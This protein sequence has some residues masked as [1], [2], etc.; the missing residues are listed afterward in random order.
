MNHKY[1]PTKKELL[2]HVIKQGLNIVL[3]W[4]LE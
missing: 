3:M 4:Y 2:V 1:D